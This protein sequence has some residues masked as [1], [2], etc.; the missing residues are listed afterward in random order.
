MSSEST[1]ELRN[2]VTETTNPASANIDCL[3]PIEIVRLMNAEDAIVAKAVAAEIPHIAAAIEQ[4]AARLRQGGRL[5]YIGV[6]T[7][8]RLGVLDASECPP[9]FNTP[10]EMVIG[11]IAGGT[12]AL[13]HAVEAVE[14]D[15]NA[16][17]SAVEQL[18][19][20]DRDAVVGISASG[21]TPYVLNAIAAA[22]ACGALTIGIACNRDAELARQVET[23]IAPVVGPEIIAGSTRL[24]AGTAQKMVLNMLSTG[25]M[26]LLGRTFGNLMVDLQGTNA[27]L[28]RRA[29][30]I[31]QVAT[32]LSE[33]E[34]S[35]L[36]QAANGEAKTAI[37]AARA[38]IDPEAA[39]QRLAAAGGSVRAALDGVAPCPH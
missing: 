32:E 16:G 10:P 22:N 29:I 19:I 28:R 35:S 11:W 7:S 21:R 23:M 25:T 12:E 14:D 4:I 8:G 20:T 37:V 24:K 17:R 27:K 9:T 26:I 15:A 31:V 13:T 38:G 39:R 30:R 34:A 6:G 3:S 2:L 5:I 18:S 36:I 1:D 33:D